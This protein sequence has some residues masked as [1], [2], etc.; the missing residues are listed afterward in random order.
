MGMNKDLPYPSGRS[1]LKWNR[2]EQPEKW[3]SVS[4][5]LMPKAKIKGRYFGKMEYEL[6]SRQNNSKVILR[7]DQVFNW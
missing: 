3:R 5:S 2:G 1:P 7:R 6:H 4:S